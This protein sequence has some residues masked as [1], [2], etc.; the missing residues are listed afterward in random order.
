MSEEIKQLIKT[1]QENLK[2]SILDAVAKYESETGMNVKIIE[3]KG[4]F[5]PTSEFGKENIHLTFYIE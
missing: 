1:S 3:Y 4:M 5:F 2:Q